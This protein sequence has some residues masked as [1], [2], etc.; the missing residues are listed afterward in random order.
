MNNANTYVNNIYQQQENGLNIFIFTI[1][2]KY[3]PET[4]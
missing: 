3:F 4:E 2:I 1:G